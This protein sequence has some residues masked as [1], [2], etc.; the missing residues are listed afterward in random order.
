MRCR[1]SC[2]PARE[3]LPGMPKLVVWNDGLGGGVKR[4][5][6]NMD[7]QNVAENG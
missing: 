7:G 1:E 2:H 6:D 3:G 5:I 4:E